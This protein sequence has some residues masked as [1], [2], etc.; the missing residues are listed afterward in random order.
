MTCCLVTECMS[1]T[2][3]GWENTVCVR[4]GCWREEWLEQYIYLVCDAGNRCTCPATFVV[5]VVSCGVGVFIESS[6]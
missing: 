4:K 3:R 6:T 5:G 2:V 1:Q